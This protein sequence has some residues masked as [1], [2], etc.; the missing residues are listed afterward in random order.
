MVGI[1]VSSMNTWLP[2]RSN[3]PLPTGREIVF[4]VPHTAW[5]IEARPQTMQAIVHAKRNGVGLRRDL[6]PNF[7]P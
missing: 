4:V 3:L 1:V 5:I 2:L 6:R 7:D